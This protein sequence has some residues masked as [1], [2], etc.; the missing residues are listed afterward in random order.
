[1]PSSGPVAP[2]RSRCPALLASNGQH[3]PLV[4]TF[5]TPV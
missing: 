2:S 4:C 5:A 1:M 3:M